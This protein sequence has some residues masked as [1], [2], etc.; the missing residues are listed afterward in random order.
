M[1]KND[2]GRED[3]VQQHDERGQAPKAER[4]GKCLKEK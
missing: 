1:G 4:E 2:T 3:A